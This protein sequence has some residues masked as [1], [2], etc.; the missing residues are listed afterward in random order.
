MIEVVIVANFYFMFECFTTP[1]NCFYFHYS[2]LF[3]YFN[4]VNYSQNTKLS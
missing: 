2:Y 1:D 3:D 4:D